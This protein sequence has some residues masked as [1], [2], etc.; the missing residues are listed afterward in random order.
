MRFL[1][2]FLV[3][4]IVLAA[5]AAGAGIGLRAGRGKFG[6]VT[7]LKPDFVAVTNAGFN[8][9][10]AARVAPGPHV[11]VFDTSLDPQARP[12]DA[13]L[14]ALHASRDD[15]T[16]VFLTHGHYDHV[17]GAAVLTKAKLHL[18]A[19]DV[20]LAAGQVNP[21][22][23]LPMLLGKLLAT[24]PVTINAPMT[25]AAAF[26]VGSTD[27]AKTVK[28]FPVPGHTPGSF[29]FL[30]DGILVAGDTMMFKEGRLVPPPRV[31]DPHHVES[32]ASVLSLKQQL[33]NETIDVVCTAHGGCT[34]KG[35]G[36]TLLDDLISRLGG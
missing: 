3:I 27:P 12:V 34:P 30:Y 1:K 31:F 2:F 8:T 32:T 4:A 28:A 14:G 26:D 10:F 22:A 7:E 17:A 16:D 33:A 19:G 21:D 15:I 18:G 29:V 6:A 13:L 20:A 35:L 23:L 24:P 36:R 11:V 5:L 9:L 25:G